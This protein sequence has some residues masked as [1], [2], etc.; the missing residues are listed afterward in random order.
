MEEGAGRAEHRFVLLGCVKEKEAGW[1]A[2]RR[3]REWA[4]GLGWLGFGSL[5]WV[6][7]VGF[8][9]LGLGFPSPFFFYFKPNSNLIEFKLYALNQFKICT[10]MNAQTC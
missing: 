2:G 10:S 8:L 3:G 4:A 6:E 5:G 9:G 1:A 7:L